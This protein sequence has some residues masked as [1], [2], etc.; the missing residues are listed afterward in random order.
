MRN[1]NINSYDKTIKTFTKIYRPKSLIGIKKIFRSAKKNKEKISFRG[2]GQSYGDQPFITSNITISNTQL[3]KI[4]DLN[5]KKSIVEVQS[6]IFL[7]NLSKFLSKY[8]YRIKCIP[9]N[10]NITIGGAVSNNVHGKDGHK[11]G[12]FCDHVE[13]IK[14]IEKNCKLTRYKKNNKNFLYNF[15]SFGLTG[16]IYSVKIKVYK[17][18]SNCLLIKREMLKNINSLKR[19]ILKINKNDFGYVWINGFSKKNIGEGYLEIANHKNHY[20]KKQELTSFNS[21]KKIIF[22]IIK[23]FNL[24]RYFFK[25]INYLYYQFVKYSKKS[26]YTTFDEFNFPHTKITNFYQNIYP[27]GFCEIQFFV[28]LN[29]AQKCIKEILLYC[30][31]FKIESFI[32]G[33]KLHKKINSITSSFSNNSISIAFDFDKRYFSDF[34]LK[35]ISKILKK[36]DCLIYLAKDSVFKSSYFGKT[37]KRNMK[38]FFKY[39]KSKKIENFFNSD[40]N[41]RLKINEIL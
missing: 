28:N 30:Q 14:V 32:I 33:V 3:N 39:L 5:H 23:L 40:Q 22:I 2:N 12:F 29:S 36:N 35:N 7:K 41:L 13:E 37:Q 17:I 24:Q 18:N 4:L 19:T 34:H 31:K 38:I 6:G 16:F 21:L 1:T 25:V 10:E 27:K 9:G 8:K 11:D 15:S 26:F 20:I